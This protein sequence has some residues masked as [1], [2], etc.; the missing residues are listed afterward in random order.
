MSTSILQGKV[1]RLPLVY[2]LRGTAG[3]HAALHQSHPLF[4]TLHDAQAFFANYRI[5]RDAMVGFIRDRGIAEPAGGSLEQFLDLSHATWLGREVDVGRL[6][7][8]ARLLL[9]DA[10]PP[11]RADPVWP[12]WRKPSRGDRTRF[13]AAGGRRYTRFFTTGGRRYIWRRAVLEAEPRDEIR[14]ERDEMMRV[15]TEL[16]AYR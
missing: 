11:L 6:N 5:F 4:W 8:A 9:G 10:V 7:H 3:S 12:G 13:S 16:D 15:E 14:I 1:A 2:A